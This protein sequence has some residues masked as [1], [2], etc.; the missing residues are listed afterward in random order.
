[1]FTVSRDGQSPF[2]EFDRGP[3]GVQFF[4]SGQTLPHVDLN[5]LYLPI[6]G[7]IMK[8]KQK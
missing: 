6:T 3:K 4:C 1:M 5:S 8:K 7:K 2:L